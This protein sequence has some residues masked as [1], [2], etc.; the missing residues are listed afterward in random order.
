MAEPDN[1]DPTHALDGWRPP[2]P[3]PLDLQI[4]SSLRIG[5]EL[6]DQAEGRLA[7]RVAE[8][9]AFDPA[10]LLDGWRAP[11]PA[12]LD[13]Q[14]RSP[15]HA[16]VTVPDAAKK[17]RL[18]A[19]G[20]EMLDVEDIELSEARPPRVAVA[21]GV[22]EMPGPLPLAEAEP[23]QL[24]EEV[25]LPEAPPA[26]AADD[27]AAAA[28]DAPPPVVETTEQGQPPAPPPA[29]PDP[30]PPVDD[31]QPSMAPHTPAATEVPML[32]FRAP[33]P[34]EPD[35]QWVIEGI[36]LPE[37]P[38]P[39]ADIEAPLLDIGALA[40]LVAPDPR[41]LVAW[42][43]QAWTALRRHVADASTEVLQTPD[44]LVVKHHA[45]QWLCAA[46]APQCAEPAP[47]QRWPELAALVSAETGADASAQL[48]AELPQESALWA[49]DLETDWGLV[50]ELVL[51]QDTAL[52]PAQALV[53][54]E[55]VATERQAH[56]A[57]LKDGYALHA[58]I[59]T[60]RP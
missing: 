3:A 59:A 30:P 57:R 7:N 28:D 51:Q 52:R 31:F 10:H 35:P 29:A 38:P 22:P 56:V 16:G 8:R 27:D 21:A 37:V 42:Q 46:W 15:L 1:F 49:T 53:L 2:A 17:A 5:G 47:L 13:L 14:L 54:R 40:P 18:K 9:E 45:P 23:R 60:R 12:P 25:Q 6:R 32:D 41:L 11:A 36:H 44:G 48:L 39:P 26:A 20:Y 58:G 24:V 43:P 55:L 4:G 34:V 19:R 50:A 33:P